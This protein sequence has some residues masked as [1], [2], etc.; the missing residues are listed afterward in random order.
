MAQHGRRER[1]D[2]L[3]RRREPA[4]LRHRLLLSYAAEA[5]GRSPDDVVAALLAAVPI[6]R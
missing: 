2:V 5:E 4:V 1:G 3:A 6:A